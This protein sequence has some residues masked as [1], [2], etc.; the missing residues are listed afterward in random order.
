MLP[1]TLPPNRAP[2]QKHLLGISMVGKLGASLAT[3]ALVAAL[4]VTLLLVHGAMSTTA[5]HSQQAAAGPA[6]PTTNQTAVATTAGTVTATVMS[7][8]VAGTP[9]TTA[10]ERQDVQVT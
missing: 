6:T 1:P 4:A 9:P 10:I 3:V 7:T 5:S 2:A 8:S